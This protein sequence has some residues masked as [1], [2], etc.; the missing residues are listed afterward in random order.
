MLMILLFH[1]LSTTNQVFLASQPLL[2]FQSRI[3]VSSNSL[4]PLI[5]F[6]R[7]VCFVSHLS[8]FFVDYDKPLEIDMLSQSCCIKLVLDLVMIL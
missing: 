8:A 5:I 2:L 7:F 3:L 1:T 4:L 6:I